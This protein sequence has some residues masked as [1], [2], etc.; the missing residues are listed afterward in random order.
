[1]EER[2]EG[3]VFPHA[4]SSHLQ[5]ALEELVKR[6]EGRDIVSPQRQWEVVKFFLCV[7]L[8]NS[9]LSVVTFTLPGKLLLFN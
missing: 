2:L 8:Y 6:F 1:M 5:A 7:Y 9:G 4:I 3:T